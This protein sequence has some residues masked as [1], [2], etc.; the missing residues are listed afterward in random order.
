MVNCA[1]PSPEAGETVSQVDVALVAE[2]DALHCGVPPAKARSTVPEAVAPLDE[3][4]SVND[5][6]DALNAA[7]AV[8]AAASDA[9]S[10]A[11]TVY[12]TSLTPLRTYDLTAGEVV[13]G[14]HNTP[15]SIPYAARRCVPKIC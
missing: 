8:D 5:A 13:P 3:A 2:I 9:L 7:G 14:K 4:D 15:C 10:D 12:P 1:A 6:G 11:V